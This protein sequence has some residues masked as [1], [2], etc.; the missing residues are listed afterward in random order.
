MI[1][2]SKKVYVYNYVYYFVAPV[3]DDPCE[4]SPCGSNAQCNNGICTCIPEY[5][6]DPYLGCRPECLLNIEC[7]LD[8]ACI[9]NRC[10]NPCTD[11]CGVNAICQ[12]NNHI[13]MCIC[14]PAMTGNAFIQCNPVKGTSYYLI[15]SVTFFKYKFKI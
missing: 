8:K 9:K 6:G 13:P 7:A 10:V 11:I 15:L 5:E 2:I 1:H 12:V 14:P 4:P 3:S